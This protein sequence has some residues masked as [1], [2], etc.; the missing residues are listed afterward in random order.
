MTRT[1]IRVVVILSVG[2]FVAGLAI[3]LVGAQ[4]TGDWY[5]LQLPWSDI[6]MILITAGLAGSA[7]F[8]ALEDV[9]EPIGRWRLLAI[10]GIT[11]GAWFWFIL[12][13]FG[14]ASTGRGAPTQSPV[15]TVLYSAPQYIAIL[16][17]AVAASALP[18]LIVRPWGRTA[19]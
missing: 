1:A 8:V 7:I 19:R 10:P 9:I 15:F 4:L 6:G 11:I 5:A 2:V 17:I 14:L 3:M 16:A 13:V 12:L 18:L